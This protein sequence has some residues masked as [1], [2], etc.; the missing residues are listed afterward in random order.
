MKNFLTIVAAAFLTACSHTSSMTEDALARAEAAIHASDYDEAREACA[1]LPDST[2]EML[3]TQLCRKALVYARL[4]DACKQPEDMD[5]AVRSYMMALAL[6][7]DSVV[8]FLDTLDAADRADF[9]LLQELQRAISEP[10]DP[11]LS[12]D[13]LMNA[14]DEE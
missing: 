3:P 2:T 7:P 14:Y 11:G 8:K 6:N 13:S 10:I 12:V 4:A 9:Y 5:I 1:S